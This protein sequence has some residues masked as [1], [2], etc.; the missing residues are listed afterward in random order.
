M[1][2]TY[3]RHP[4]RG[5]DLLD[6]SPWDCARWSINKLMCDRVANYFAD[7][8]SDFDKRTYSK[9]KRCCDRISFY[10]DYTEPEGG[11]YPHKLLYANFCHQRACLLCQGRLANKW[12]TR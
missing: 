2:H 5:E 3:R 4:T 7:S 12:R 10:R 1:T 8:D 11:R 9:L 6:F